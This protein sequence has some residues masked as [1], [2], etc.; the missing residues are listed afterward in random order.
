MCDFTGVCKNFSFYIALEVNMHFV[1][2]ASR[3]CPAGLG[4]CCDPTQ[5]PS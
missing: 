5:V 2:A 3:Q 1:H 4:L